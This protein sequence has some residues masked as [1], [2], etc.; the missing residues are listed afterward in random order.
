MKAMLGTINIALTGLNA[1]TNRL[2]AS[3]SNIANLQTVGSLDDA[4]SAPYNPLTTQ[5]TADQNGGVRSE[6]VARGNAFSP[7]F[8]PDSHFANEDGL[9]GVPNIDLAEETVNITLAEIQYKANIKSI[10]AASE[11]ADEL[12]RLFD[13]TA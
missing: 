9:V 7:G 5:Q 1:A 4:E 2:S 13:D 11:L 12:D 6:V 10:E 8:D 3:A